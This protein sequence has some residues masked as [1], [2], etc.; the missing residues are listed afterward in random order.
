MD[1]AELSTVGLGE[2][3]NVVEVC[4]AGVYEAGE[5][6]CPGP[7]S[8]YSRNLG[9]GWGVGVCHTQDTHTH[10]S[11]HACVGPGALEAMLH[12]GGGTQNALCFLSL[13]FLLQL[14][15]DWVR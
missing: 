15:I 4:E 9:M 3:N 10:S 14:L 6:E 7:D 5:L 1:S 12:A 2:S 13:S 8:M 11:M